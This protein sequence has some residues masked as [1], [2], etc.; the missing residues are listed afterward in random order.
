MTVAGTIISLNYWPQALN[1][2]K[3]FKAFNQDVP[4]YILILDLDAEAMS[5]GYD[6]ILTLEKLGLSK[7]QIEY[8]QSKYD[9]VEFATAMKPWLLKY[10][11]NLGYTQAIFFDPDMYFYNSLPNEIYSNTS[12]IVLTPHRL[13]PVTMENPSLDDIEAQLLRYGSFN[14][15]FIAVSQNNMDF[16]DW[17][18]LK[19]EH[20][21]TRNRF[22]QYFTDQKWIDL[23]S[24][25]WPVLN[26]R[27]PGFNV[28]PWNIDE[29]ELV[30][31]SDGN[32][33]S[34]GNDLIFIH[35]SQMSSLLQNGVY[36]NHWRRFENLDAN[37]LAI[38]EKLV[39]SYMKNLQ[40]V[41]SINLYISRKLESKSSI[42]RI[43]N[44]SK[45]T[46][47]WQVYLY[48]PISYLFKKLEKSSL[49]VFLILGLKHDFK[50]IKIRITK[51]FAKNS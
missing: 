8:F 11:L 24:T 23:A 30:L 38:I 13:S 51:F 35:F 3:S 4:F 16:L 31:T 36:S 7:H 47:T 14:L 10:L 42:L 5:S 18:L 9:V 29:R 33:R 49:L 20:H 44:I 41:P 22:D 50:S 46:N 40:S 12:Q 19:L 26:Y 34:N 37:Q 28:A 15:G 17:W 48:Q 1:A 25:Y 32:L 39:S 21:S 27:H 2:Q 45:P 6:Y 43:L